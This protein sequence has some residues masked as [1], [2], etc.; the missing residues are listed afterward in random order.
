M[1][2]LTK[3]FNAYEFRCKCGLCEASDNKMDMDFVKTL[4]EARDVA[5][6]LLKITSGFRCSQHPE[7]LKRPTSSHTLGLAV[8]IAT[9]DSSSRHNIVRALIRVGLSRIGIGKNFVHVDADLDKPANVMWD[10]YG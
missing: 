10:Y 9:P 3:N 4:Q 8:D 5:G 2:D 7:S 6:R 1:G